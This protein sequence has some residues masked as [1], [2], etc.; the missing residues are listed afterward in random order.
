MVV[1]VMNVAQVAEALDKA[2]MV[3]FNPSTGHGLPTLMNIDRNSYIKFRCIS[4]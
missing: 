3:R 1:N 4:K 2:H